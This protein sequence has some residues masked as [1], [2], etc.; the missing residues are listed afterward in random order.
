VDPGQHAVAWV[1]AAGAAIAADEVGL[2]DVL[3]ERATSADRSYPTYYGAAWLALG[4][5]WLTTD[6]LGGCAGDPI[7]S[8]ASH[9]RSRIRPTWAARMSQL[10]PDPGVAGRAV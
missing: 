6:L 5:L 7:E 4:R 2:A 9:G 1:G 3:L 8:I 10:N